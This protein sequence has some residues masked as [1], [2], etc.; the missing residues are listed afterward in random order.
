M[1][2][3]VFVYNITYYY[4]VLGTGFDEQMEHVLVYSWAYEAILTGCIEF[5]GTQSWR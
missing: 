4:V 1:T 3:T 5:I 2:Y